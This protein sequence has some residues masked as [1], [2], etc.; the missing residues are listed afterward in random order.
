MFIINTLEKVGLSVVV[1]SGT[2]KLENAVM[3]ATL[4][5]ETPLSKGSG[6]RFL[7][8]LG[9]PIPFRTL[10]IVPDSP[11]DGRS[12]DVLPVLSSKIPRFIG[13]TDKAGFNQYR[14]HRSMVQ[15]YKASLLDTARSPL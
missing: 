3:P 11:K 8:R 5:P 6:K 2:C 13:I 10:L 15:H 4:P 1:K 9:L 7:F 14:R 12:Y